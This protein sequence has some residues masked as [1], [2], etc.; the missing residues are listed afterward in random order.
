MDFYFFTVKVE[1][2][3]KISAYESLLFKRLHAFKD[4]SDGNINLSHAIEQFGTEW[5]RQLK[6]FR[7][8]KIPTGNRNQHELF[9]V[10]D[11]HE[12][13]SEREIKESYRY[14][15]YY[16]ETLI[17]VA[18]SAEILPPVTATNDSNTAVAQIFTDIAR[19]VYN[20]LYS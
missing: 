7:M 8:I 4:C 11:R 13:Q 10:G 3:Q 16:V 17:E 5:P 18:H 12:R 19:R 15:N 9:V 14:L 1:H 20:D 6:H 2:P